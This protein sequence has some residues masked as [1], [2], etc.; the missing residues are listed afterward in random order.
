[1]TSMTIQ[2]E[3]PLL[4]TATGGLELNRFKV[5]QSP[6]FMADLQWHQDS[7]PRPHVFR[8][9]MFTH[10]TLLGVLCS[11]ADWQGSVQFVAYEETKSPRLPDLRYFIKAESF[12][13]DATSTGKND[14]RVWSL[15]CG[16][17]GR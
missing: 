5:H 8:A 9:E 17:L 15:D 2:L 7:N 11:E 12:S 6:L 13:A 10:K 4:K 3:T 16:Y 14:H 1:M